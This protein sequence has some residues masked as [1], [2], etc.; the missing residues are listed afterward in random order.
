VTDP[1]PHPKLPARLR[2]ALV[3]ALLD[4]E[5][6]RRRMD[7]ALQSADTL[8]QSI[9]AA[10]SSGL[11]PAEAGIFD[12]Y[13]VLSDTMRTAVETFDGLTARIN[14]LR[15]AGHKPEPSC[16]PQRLPATPP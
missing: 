5:Q 12:Y 6:T 15:Q 1:H 10:I 9:D 16:T 14:E 7:D 11:I 3:D 4:L 8:E 13:R 2:S